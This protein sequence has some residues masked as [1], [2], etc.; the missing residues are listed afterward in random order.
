MV[1]SRAWQDRWSCSRVLACAEGF[2]L[3]KAVDANADIIE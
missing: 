1:I 3:L 2:Q